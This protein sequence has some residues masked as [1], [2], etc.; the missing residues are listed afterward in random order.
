MS[1]RE[2]IYSS[3]KDKAFF[4]N[5]LANQSF[6][7]FCPLTFCTGFP[8]SRKSGYCSCPYAAPP[9][10]MRQLAPSTTTASA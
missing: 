10:D 8:V 7:F 9:D 4:Q 6:D 2:L 1:R 5:P 3:N